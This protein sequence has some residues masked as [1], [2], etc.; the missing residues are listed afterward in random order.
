M[1]CFWETMDGEAGN[2]FTGSVV[3]WYNICFQN[4]PANRQ[5]YE[6]IILRATG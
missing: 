1:L 2:A 4:K 5:K 6:T 3:Y